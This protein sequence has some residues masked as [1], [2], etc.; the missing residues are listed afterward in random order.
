MNK[1]QFNNIKQKALYEDDMEA[2]LELGKFFLNNGEIDSAVTLL[3]MAVR[4][5]SDEACICLG[6]LYQE[7][8][9]VQCDYD[10]ASAL[11]LKAAFLK[12]IEGLYKYGLNVYHGLVAELDIENGIRI[13]EKSALQGYYKAQN[14]IAMLY[15]LGENKQKDYLQA[16]KWFSLSA[17]Q[18]YKDAQFNLALMYIKGEVDG[19]KDYTKALYW[20]NKAAEQLDSEAISYIGY[21]Y[22][23]GL[24]I[25]VDQE[26]AVDYFLQAL[27]IDSCNE[28]A[29][30]Q[31]FNLIQKSGLGGAHKSKLFIK[32]LELAQIMGSELAEKI[33]QHKTIKFTKHLHNLTNSLDN[34][35][36]DLVIDE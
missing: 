7:G 30:K 34:W 9:N 21:M 20:F 10:A 2:Q 33:L 13:M 28:M 35:V 1:E 17:N 5:D 12:N 16:Y 6:D 32:H 31:L 25:D 18:G 36:V 29:L 11:F 24:G 22:L 15:L 14:E 3:E 19:E 26:K 23:K 4:N 8:I 27:D